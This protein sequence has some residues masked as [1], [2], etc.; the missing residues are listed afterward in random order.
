MRKIMTAD[1]LLAAWRRAK[2]AAGLGADFRR[3]DGYELWLPRNTEQLRRALALEMPPTDAPPADAPLPELDDLA[4]ALGALEADSRVVLFMP[5]VF[6]RAL[7]VAGS[8]AA[9]RADACKRRLASIAGQRPNTAFV[10]ARRDSPPTREAKNFID[11][12]HYLD[13]VAI[14][15]EAEL[16]AAINRLGG[17]RKR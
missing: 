2:I 8:R 7:P 3:R 13:P 10:D 15:A 4:H 6:S 17:D 16:I 1:S 11:A 14:P 9:A 5:P 12:T